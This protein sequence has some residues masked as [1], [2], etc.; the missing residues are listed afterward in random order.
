MSNVNTVFYKQL[1]FILG[2]IHNVCCRSKIN[3]RTEVSKQYHHGALDENKIKFMSG[4]SDISSPL[5][6]F[7]DGFDIKRVSVVSE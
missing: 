7:C 1:V 5:D 3:L 6:Q 4:A 2:E